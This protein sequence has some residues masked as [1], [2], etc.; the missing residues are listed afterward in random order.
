MELV[1]SSEVSADFSELHDIETQSIVLFIFT[2]ELTLQPVSAN[3]CPFFSSTLRM[4]AI[5]SSETSGSLQT[6]RRYAKESVL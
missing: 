3:F 2:A 1:L 6:T 4:E 5:L